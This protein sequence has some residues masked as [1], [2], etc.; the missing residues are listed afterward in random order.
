MILP[1]CG[2]TAVLPATLMVC[3]RVPNPASLSVSVSVSWSLP[4]SSPARR[5]N[6]A[7]PRERLRPNCVAYVASAS[8][9]CD[10]EVEPTPF[11]A[12]RTLGRGRV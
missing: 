10:L 6:P 4:T 8:S 9:S 12:R 7:D 1:A 5:D 3:T 11:A 2:R